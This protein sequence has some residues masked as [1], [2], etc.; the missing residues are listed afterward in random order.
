MYAAMTDA[1][2][3]CLENS[4]SPRGILVTPS[5]DGE[6]LLF[7]PRIALQTGAGYELTI[8]DETLR[9][10]LHFSE[11]MALG[12]LREMVTLSTADGTL[13]ASPFPSLEA[14][15]WDHSQARATL[16]VDPDRIK[17]GVGPNVAGG[18][19]L[20]VGQSYRLTV[21]QEMRSAAAAPL[22]GNLRVN[23]RFGPPE[24]HAISPETWEI[25]APTAGSYAPLSLAFD[26]IM[27]SGTA[28]RLIAIQARDGPPVLGQITSDGGG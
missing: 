25:L 17:Q 10:Y 9:L 6:E 26:R 28:L 8:A 13:V 2:A 27:D 5:Q 14:E 7:P 22:G 12:Q 19:P 11:P 24:R 20:Q 16:L 18:A 1:D 23:F 15:L 3:V 21:S 4:P